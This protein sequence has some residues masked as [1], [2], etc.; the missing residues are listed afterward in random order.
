MSGLFNLKLLGKCIPRN[1]KNW[2]IIH[3]LFVY[4]FLHSIILCACF[5]K[6]TEVI[7]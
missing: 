2:T 6:W 5:H 3:I 7:F 1:F 4:F